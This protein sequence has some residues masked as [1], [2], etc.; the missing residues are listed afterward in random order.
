MKTVIAILVLILCPSLAEAQCSSGYCRTRTRTWTLRRPV[1]RYYRYRTMRYVA[2]NVR[3][4]Q[5][6]P[7]RKPAAHIAPEIAP[8]PDPVPPP[9]PAQKKTA[10]VD[11]PRSL[12]ELMPAVTLRTLLKPKCVT[13]PPSA[14]DP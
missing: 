8:I 3:Y 7:V 1:V 5:P 11:P 12:S 10:T 2:P 14:G 6:A 4:V 13:C 9:A